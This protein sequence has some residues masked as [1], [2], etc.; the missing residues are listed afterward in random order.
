MGGCRAIIYAC[1]MRCPNCG[2]VFPM[3]KKFYFVPELQQQLSEED[4]ERYD[5]LRQ[6][7]REAYERNFAPAW[8]AT[9]YKK[10][11][12]YWPPDSWGRGAV[13]GINPTASQKH[14]YRQYLKSVAQRKEK[15]DS[16]V[17]HSMYLEFGFLDSALPT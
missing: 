10:H 17:E 8:A 6:K 16:W 13:F 7:I 14:S 4:V 2:Y 3:P 9:T 5:F 1:L 15:S 11:Y 12:G